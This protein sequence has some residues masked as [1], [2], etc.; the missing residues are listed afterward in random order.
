MPELVSC[1]YGTG[2]IVIKGVS[3]ICCVTCQSQW[4]QTRS[5]LFKQR[6]V[7]TTTLSAD[8]CALDLC[9]LCLFVKPMMDWIHQH[10]PQDA[11]TSLF[12]DMTTYGSTQTQLQVYSLGWV[13]IGQKAFSCTWVRFSK[14]Y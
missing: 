12:C 13:R 11:L 6:L 8:F 3:S 2:Q 7:L 10:L 1:A 14:I 9:E 5:P 4:H